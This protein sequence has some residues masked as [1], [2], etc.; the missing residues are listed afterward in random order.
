MVQGTDMDCLDPTVNTN[1]LSVILSP[2]SSDTKGQL[3][4]YLSSENGYKKGFG[5]GL[6]ITDT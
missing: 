6:N 2:C 1:G 5:F 3:G 4:L